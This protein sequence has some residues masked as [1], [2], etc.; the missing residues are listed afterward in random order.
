[1]GTRERR[2]RDFELREQRFV[3]AGRELIREDGLLN[4]QMARVADRCE[5]AVGTLYQHFVSKE[6]LLLEIARKDIE[7]HVSLFERVARWSAPARDR[8]IAMTVADAVFFSHNPEHFQLIQ[9]VFCDVVWRSAPAERRQQV[10]ATQAPIS[11]IAV[12]IVDDGV[13]A[14]DLDRGGLSSWGVASASW[15]QALGMLNLLHAEGLVEPISMVQP[16]RLMCR[17]M[18]VL[19]NGFG[20]QPL[21]D[22]SD[23]AAL[24]ALINRIRTEVFHDCSAEI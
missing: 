17:H 13:A 7:A 19:L 6:D 23:D 12:G 21:V 8:M 11:A 1:M 14:G 18:Q 15:A 3:E 9:Y 24:D 22:V 10:L 20:W 2:Q 16:Y 4:L 5:Y